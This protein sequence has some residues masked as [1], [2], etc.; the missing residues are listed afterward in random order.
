MVI[1][2]IKLWGVSRNVEF[3]CCILQDCFSLKTINIYLISMSYPSQIDG[4]RQD[5]FKD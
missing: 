5:L 2:P 1:G 3:S 4:I